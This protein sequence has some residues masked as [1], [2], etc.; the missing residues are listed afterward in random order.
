MSSVECELAKV[1]MSESHDH[2]VV[3][4]Q[5]KGGERKFPIIIGFF[6]VYA[7]HRFV[8]N[9]VPARPLTHELIGSMLKTLD[10]SVDR[11]VVNDLKNRTFYARIVLQ[12]QNK[13]F[14]VDSRPSDAI[15][16]AVQTGA[17]IFVAEHVLEEASRDFG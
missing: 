2:Q 9:D 13:T 15:A 14:E 7:I 17:P 8:N 10:V 3:I 12:Q 5:Q 11:I 16:I 6:E 1:I 4:L